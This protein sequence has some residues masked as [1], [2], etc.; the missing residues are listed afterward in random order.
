MKKWIWISFVCLVSIPLIIWFRKPLFERCMLIQCPFENN[1]REIDLKNVMPFAW[2]TLFY[3]G[4]GE[5]SKDIYKITG[6]DILKD[7]PWYD[8]DRMLLNLALFMKDGKL[9]YKR[10]W[11]YNY[12]DYNCPVLFYPDINSFSVPADS[13]CFLLQHQCNALILTSPLITTQ[14]QMDRLPAIIDGLKQEHRPWFINL[15]KD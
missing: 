13:A 2:D 12:E 5:S 8:G 6:Y 9:K 11:D 14:H 3:F 10:I 7:E 1:E 4:R 15:G